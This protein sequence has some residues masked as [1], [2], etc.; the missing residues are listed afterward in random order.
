MLDFLNIG[1]EFAK[2][3][4]TSEHRRVLVYLSIYQARPELPLEPD[5]LLSAAARHRARSQLVEPLSWPADWLI[6]KTAL[7]KT[8]KEF[9][10][11]TRYILNYL[12]EIRRL[13]LVGELPEPSA[14]SESI[15]DPSTPPSSP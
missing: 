1:Y 13:P 6:D 10:K 3:T 2:R 12:N 5:S 14:N 11:S 7:R 8:L 9:E 15:P 4:Y